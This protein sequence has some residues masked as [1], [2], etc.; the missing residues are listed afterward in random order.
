MSFSLEQSPTTGDEVITNYTINFGPQHPAAHGVL[1]MVMELDGEIIE[2]IDPHVGLLHRGTE[3]LIEHKTYLQALPYFD[4]LDYCSPLAM[5]HSYV[6][7]VEK[8]LNI[9]VPL[10]A[11]YLRVLFA[12]LTR[13]CNH[14]LNIGSHVMDVGAMTP[15]LWLFEIR[16]DCLTFFER[17]SGARMHSAWFRPGGVHQDVPLKLLTDM[18]DWLDTRLPQLFDDAMSLVVD[19]RIFKQRNVDIAVVSK[20]DA[21]RWGF[22]G[23]MIRGSGIPWDI[24]KAQPY[25]VYNRM[26]FD[27]PVGTR[28]DCY[29]RMMVR[30][31]EVRQSARIMKQ[32]LAQMPEGP[33]HSDDRK[34]MP[35]KRAE[36]KSSMESLIHHFKL[37]TEGFHVPAGEVYVATES[38]KGEF[39]VYLVSDGTNKP[40]RCK[41]RP[42]A[43]SH[44]QAMDFM[45]KGHMLPDATAILG[46]IDVVF[47]ECDR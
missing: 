3:K 14:M 4:R 35:P 8:L 46:A 12:E 19:N 20:D 31:E 28:G 42:T 27:I 1:R 2:R 22:S 24:R 43:F 18:A 32:C 15:N 25:D 21:V 16:E 11:Q 30:V 7:A 33:V 44:L 34:V 36:M 45:S 5:E 37:Y 39:G 10:R 38:P 29:D 23:P 6:L 9:A 26:E 47:G 41:I 17:A 40:Y 13:I